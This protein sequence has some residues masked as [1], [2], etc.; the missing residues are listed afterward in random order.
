M[1]RGGGVRRRGDRTPSP[2]APAHD[3]AP[4]SPDAP[5]RLLLPRVHA[6]TAAQGCRGRRAGA[7]RPPPTLPRPA[8]LS[9]HLTRRSMMKTPWMTDRWFT[10]PHNFS[11]DVRAQL[12]FAK[13]IVFHDITLR[14]GEQQTGVVFTKDDKIRIAEKLA[15]AGVHRI[16]AGMPTVAKAD[17]AEGRFG[18]RPSSIIGTA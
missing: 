5:C 8:P 14:D 13:K 18:S 9:A 6:R 17:E 4:G 1:D 2:D 11:E 16:E 12:K 3:L 10:S 15:E 7:H